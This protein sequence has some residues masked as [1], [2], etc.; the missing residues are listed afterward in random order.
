[1]SD[2][3]TLPGRLHHAPTVPTDIR[4]DVPALPAADASAG[5]SRL[6]AMKGLCA[7]PHPRDASTPGRPP[8]R[9]APRPSSRSASP[10]SADIAIRAAALAG[11]WAARVHGQGNGQR[12][13][14]A[15]GG[16]S[17]SHRQ[18]RQTAAEKALALNPTMR[19][20]V[21]PFRVRRLPSASPSAD[22]D[23]IKFEPTQGV[24]TFAVRQPVLRI[25]PGRYVESRTF[26]KPG[27]YYEK[28]GGAWPGEVGPFYIEGA[29][30]GDTLVVR[31]LKLRPN[32]DTAVSTSVPTGSA[33]WP[34]IR[35]RACS[36]IRCRRAGSSGGSI[37][38]ATSASSICRTRRRSDRGAA[39]PDARPAR[40]RAGGRRGVRR[41]VAGQLRRQHG[42]SDAREGTTVYLPI[43]H[44]GALLL[45]RRRPRA[46]GR[47]RDLRL[48]PRDDDG[49][50][51]PVRPDQRASGSAGRGWRTPTTSWWPAAAGRSSTRSASRRSS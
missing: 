34:A 49:R 45:L 9:N 27:D 42:R 35:G 43:F 51:V 44:D 48:G 11:P 16:R 46:A 14:P 19:R 28:D 40:G 4:P 30:P 1:M 13:R 24:P 8:E 6:P 29:T 15:R 39:Q 22:A 32:R 12:I 33:P 7:A 20:I 47:R 37:A 31:I 25:K 26:S 5:M 36:T 10:V 3:T 2:Q 38:R 41:P 17:G 50:D 18:Q 21:I 23:V